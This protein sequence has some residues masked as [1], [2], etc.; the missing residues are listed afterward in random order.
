MYP[1][2]NSNW[3][4]SVAMFAHVIQQ[5]LT[6]NHVLYSSHRSTGFIFVEKGVNMRHSPWIV[7]SSKRR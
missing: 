1:Y 3:N 7:L 4:S 6:V 2:I 5:C